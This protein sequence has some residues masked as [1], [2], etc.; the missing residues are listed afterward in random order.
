MF[1]TVA[2]W[3]SLAVLVA[4]VV[5]AILQH[6]APLAP[7]APPAATAAIDNVQERIGKYAVVKL[8]ADLS[9]L[10]AAERDVL[11]HLMRASQVMDDLYWQQSYGDK[12][13]LLSSIADPALRQLVDMN[14]GPWE[15]LT[16]FQPLLTGIGARPPGTNLYPPNISLAELNTLPPALRDDG[17]SI[18]RR[19]AAGKLQVIPYSQAYGPQLAI[20]AN[21]LRQAAA[22]TT[23]SALQ[24]YLNARA[25]AFLS[26]NYR[27]SDLAWLDMK[28]NRIE[29]VIGPVESY[30][31]GLL[32]LRTN[33]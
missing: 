14:Y 33:C 6:R 21:E 7:A 29:T 27:A 24:R 11:L 31:D 18:V 32:G 23:D 16:D 12:H 19:D 28:G 5:V 15:R 13:A 1:T 8:T 30:E 2:R 26:N 25:A 22:L 3:L 10:T 17:Y 9:A 4:A 20:A